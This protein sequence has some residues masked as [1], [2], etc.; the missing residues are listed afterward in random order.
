MCKKNLATAILSF[1]FLSWI[2]GQTTETKTETK[3]QNRDGKTET[4][5]HTETQ[6][7]GGRTIT[8]TTYTSTVNMNAAFGIKANANMSNYI[9][10]DMDN[11]SSNMGLGFSAGVFIKLESNHFVLQYELLLQRKVS[12]MEHPTGQTEE[13]KYWG[14]QLPIYFM[15]QIS[16]GSGKIVIGSGPFVSV[17]LDSTRDPGTTDLYRKDQ[18]NGKSIM[19]RWDFGLGIIAGYEFGSGISIN[20]SYQAGLIN[21][22]NEEKYSQTMRNQ[23]ISFGIGYKF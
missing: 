14:L 11:Y 16:A 4:Y 21:S 7:P 6:Q 15:G 13:Y 17:G 9:I 22:L 12:E 19:H 8:T 5:T 10:R 18:T 23:V 3:S 20:C 1:V 2:S